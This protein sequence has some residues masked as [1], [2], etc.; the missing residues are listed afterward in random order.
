VLRRRISNP[1]VHL[2]EDLVVALDTLD[3]PIRHGRAL[4]QS[5]AR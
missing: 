3:R 5:L 4:P 2:A 1:L